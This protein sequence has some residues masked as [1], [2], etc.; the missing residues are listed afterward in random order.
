MRGLAGGIGRDYPGC[1]HYPHRLGADGDQGGF[2]NRVAEAEAEGEDHQQ[3]ER[4]A[5]CQRL[6]HCLAYGKQCHFKAADE[7]RQPQQHEQEA[8]CQIG[9]VVDRLAQHDDLEERYN[10]QDRH[11]I[12]GGSAQ[13]P[14]PG[15]QRLHHLSGG[16][17]LFFYPI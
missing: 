4:A 10:Q 13:Q 9:Q 5:L 14:G 11:Q 2:G 6:R 3:A 1:G 16:L 15:T 7:H 12:T 8:D 17:Y